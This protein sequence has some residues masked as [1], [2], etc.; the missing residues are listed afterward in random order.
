M[1]DP[2]KLRL[3]LDE[4]ARTG[5]R[6]KVVGVGGGGSNAVNRMVANG[7]DGVEFI[8]ANTD[9]QA[10][11][12]NPAGS[13]LQ[14]GAKLTKGLGAGADPNIGR[15]AALEDTDK[16]IEALDGADMVFVTTG[17]GGGTGTGAAP[18]IASLASELG[19][20]TIAVVTKPFRFE[21]KKRALQAERGL[22][23]LRASVDTVIT[24]PNERLLATIGR[25]TSLN[26]AF[27]T[28]DDVLRQAI[29]GISDL[30]LV[31][32]LINLDFADVKTIMSGMGLAIMGTGTA[33][34]DGRAMIAANA[35]ISSPLLED[36]SVAGARG[37]IINVTGGSDLSLIEVSEASAVIQEAAHEEANIIFGAVVDP[38]MEGQVKITVIATGFDRGAVQRTVSASS[39]QTP[40]DLHSYS[41]WKQESNE[42][43]AVAGGGGGR[44]PITVQRRP[45]LD[46]PL[47]AVNDSAR[48]GGDG[49][50]DFESS[51]LDVPAFLR[52]QSE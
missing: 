15:Q 10:L 41:A 2:A 13:K 22:E 46:L 29:Q 31:P 16:L 40:V 28:A 37:V 45:A 52:R 14:I 19:A 25:T 21:G 47:I 3:K 51:P 32:G 1:I 27:A 36:A 4:E 5:A 44:M 24:I 39:A 38:K 26:D 9:L 8:V 42:K 49:E 11:R 33:T 43:I 12:L 34:G 7:F 18:V 35:A 17:L 48:S 20:L 30:I 50:G 6:I 23:E